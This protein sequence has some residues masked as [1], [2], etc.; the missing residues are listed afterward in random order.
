MNRSTSCKRTAVGL[1]VVVALL[2]TVACSASGSGSADE[3][4]QTQ[5]AAATESVAPQQ[6]DASAVADLPQGPREVWAN[7][8]PVAQ[9]LTRLV[10]AELATTPDPRAAARVVLESNTFEADID[11][12]PQ[13]IT[14]RVDEHSCFL[15]YRDAAD[16]SPVFFSCALPP[17]DIVKSAKAIISG[18]ATDISSEAE[19]LSWEGETDALEAIRLGVAG[20]SGPNPWSDVWFNTDPDAEG[21]PTAIVG[22]TVLGYTCTLDYS[23]APEATEDLV[24][25]EV[26]PLCPH[27]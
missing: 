13:V 20:S 1:A 9:E 19:S 24:G 18:L 21:N 25:F 6:D 27:P 3:G 17:K 23:D 2:G 8:R 5:A 16:R 10:R 15:N 12:D 11:R 26:A 14:V 4:A 22:A 7:A